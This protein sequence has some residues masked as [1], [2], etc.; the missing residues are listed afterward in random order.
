MSLKYVPPEINENATLV[1]DMLES[2]P[3]VWLLAC[4]PQWLATHL[5]TDLRTMYG[6]LMRGHCS[7]GWQMVIA[8]SSALGTTGGIPGK[9]LD[10]ESGWLGF[11]HTEATAKIYSRK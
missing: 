2:A 8:C 7:W 6:E 5:Q 9:Y 3:W 11:L 10:K 1:L 4:R